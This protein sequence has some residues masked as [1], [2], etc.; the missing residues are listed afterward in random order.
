M[1]FTKGVHVD[2][3]HCDANERPDVYEDCN[4]QPCDEGGK[5][6]SDYLRLAVG[7]T[8]FCAFYC[9]IGFPHRFFGHSNVSQSFFSGHLTPTHPPP[10]KP[11]NIRVPG[12]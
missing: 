4:N 8:N 12:V 11:N 7:L 10:R 2:S 1:C 6:T 9:L 5:Y 3:S